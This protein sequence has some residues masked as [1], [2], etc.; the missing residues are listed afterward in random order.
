MSS[1]LVLAALLSVLPQQPATQQQ[2][3]PPLAVP[4]EHTRPAP[5]SIT[6]ARFQRILWLDARQAADPAVLAAVRRLGY[7]ACN[8][9]QG[10]DPAPLAAAGLAC[11]IDQPA[12]KGLLEMRDQDWQPLAAAYEKTRDPSVLRRPVCLQDDKAVAAAAAAAVA[13]V[14]RI[15]T[16]MALFVAL[17]DEASATR[18][19]NPLDLCTCPLCCAAFRQFLQR[20]YGTLAALNDA[21]QT[22]FASW[23]D[24]VPLSTDYIRR[25]ELGGAQ[26]PADL[27]PWSDHLDF[28]DQQFAGVVGTL[29][30]AVHGVAP[31]LP[32]G[33]TGVQPP[34]AFGGHDYARLVPLLSACEVYDVGGAKAL[35]RS[36]LP[37]GARRF[38]T[39]FPAK[40][41]AAPRLPTGSLAEA[42]AHGL[43]G[44]VVWNGAEVLGAGDAPSP[45]GAAVQE[46]FDRMGPV[47]DACAGAEMETA[48]LWLVESQASVRAWWM[49]D[50]AGDGMTWL[51]RVGSYEATHSTSLAARRSWVHLCQ[52]LGLQ[53]RFVAATDLPERLLR[54]RPACLVLPACIA[55]SDRDCQAIE[56]YVRT[57]GLLVA[58]HSAALYDE[59]LRLRAAGGLDAVFGIQARSLRWADLLVLGGVAAPAAHLL[60]GSSAAESGLVPAR[61]E[62]GVHATVTETAGRL[63]VFFEHAV[64]RGRAVYMNSAVCDYDRVRLQEDFVHVAM[65]LRSRLRAALRATG[66]SAPFEVHAEGLPTCVERVVLHLRDG[67]RVLGCRLN[68]LDRPAVLAHVAKHVTMVRLDLPWKAHLQTLDGKDLGTAD[69]FE[70]P[71]DAFAG[72]FVVERDL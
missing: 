60:S 5:A 7:T 31:D 53:P 19:T 63:Q 10:Q 58:D 28:V 57:G 30:G 37:P 47:L 27:T 65:D 25:R 6:D 20:A 69:S 34:A 45:F 23:D 17:A 29:V 49:L 41:E 67:R 12:G 42:A 15:G 39:L 48:P 56:A 24:V 68:A 13:E 8:L 40:G 50:S 55:L 71:F 72:L 36:L 26:L 59:H 14:Q 66:I 3:R 33:L 35:A 62:P 16:H 1:T 11:Y 4:G 43:A 2:L 61:E 64:G 46:A 32:V 51:R 22:T 44:A 54:E 21:W 18:H 70:L 38:M 52:D 9:G